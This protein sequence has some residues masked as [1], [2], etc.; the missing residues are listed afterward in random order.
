MRGVC[1]GGGGGVLAPE[2]LRNPTSEVLL[3]PPEP[4]TLN[5]LQTFVQQ[6]HSEI[7]ESGFLG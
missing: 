3:H 1:G 7:A 2:G 4:E 6:G 5:Q